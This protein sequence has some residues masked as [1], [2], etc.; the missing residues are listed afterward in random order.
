MRD[1]SIVVVRDDGKGDSNPTFRFGSSGPGWRLVYEGLEGFEGI[2]YEVST[3]D[4]AQYD[5]A[6]L[7]NERSPSRDRTISA[8]RFGDP[9]ALRKQAESF[10][11]PKRE[12]EVHVA[13]DGR[14]RFVRARQYAFSLKVDSQTGGQLL[15]WTFL[16]LDPYWMSEDSKAFDIAEARGK[17]GF[18]F[19]SFASRVVPEPE[20]MAESAGSPAKHIEG[21]VV[22]VLSQ[23]V[24]MVNAGGAEAYPVFV[25]TATDRVVNPRITVEDEA[26][27]VVCEVGFDLEMSDGDAVTVDFS[28]RPTSITLN[29]EN[30]S[31]LTTAGSTLAA[32]IGVGTFALNWSAESGDAAL[33]VVPTIR[34]RYAT[35]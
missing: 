7:L 10:F 25:M 19:V 6:Y 21:F 35:I 30:V 23:R 24:Q 14:C 1:V 18:P 29:G 12:Y 13:A 28:Q 15:D 27:N 3:G 4:Y 9:A 17:F 16:S 5:G 33:S 34:E 26:G 32:G 8:V 2:D 20:A 31:Q 22:G 11:V